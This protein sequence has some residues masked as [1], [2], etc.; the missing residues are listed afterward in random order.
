MRSPRA[1]PLILGTLGFI[2]FVIFRRAREVR[3]SKGLCASKTSSLLNPKREVTLLRPGVVHIKYALT[4]DTQIQVARNMFKVGHDEKRWWCES[5]Q[6]PSKKKIA[7]EGFDGKALLKR[8]ELTGER[9]GR[10]RVYDAITN[11]GGADELLGLPNHYPN[12]N[13]NPN[14]NQTQP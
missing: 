9:Q 1:W 11:F 13:P 3:H 5:K 10:G 8:W 12:P 6:Q 4:M 2:F 14:P 7:L